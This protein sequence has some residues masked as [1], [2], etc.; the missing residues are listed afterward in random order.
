MAKPWGGKLP[1][2]AKDRTVCEGGGMDMRVGM[3]SLENTQIGQL[4]ILLFKDVQMQLFM[5]LICC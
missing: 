5:Y 1:P 3:L 2:L 4:S